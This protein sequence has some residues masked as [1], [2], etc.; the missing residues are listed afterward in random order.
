[1]NATIE[2]IKADILSRRVNILKSITGF[3]RDIYSKM[4]HAER[5]TLASFRSAVFIFGYKIYKKQMV[6]KYKPKEDAD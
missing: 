1:M 6:E 3:E 4:S 2:L 5:V